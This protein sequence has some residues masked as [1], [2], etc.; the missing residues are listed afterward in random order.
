MHDERVNKAK[1]TVERAKD[2]ASRVKVLKASKVEEQ[3]QKIAEK[4][5][6]AEKLKETKVCVCVPPVLCCDRF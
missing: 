3:K 4:L 2:T 5:E 1:Q 6:T